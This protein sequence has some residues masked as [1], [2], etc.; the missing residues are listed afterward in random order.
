MVAT[1]A[2]SGNVQVLQNG[3]MSNGGPFT[4]NTPQITSID[5]TS[6]ASGMTVTISGTG[7]GRQSTGTVWL[8]STF[9]Q[10]TSWTD[11]Q[12]VAVVAPTA[13]TGS[14]ASNRMEHGATR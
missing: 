6:G 4:V 1:G 2:A 10:V 9:G 5:P 11:T 8:G 12:V 13:V 7:F 14:L 3:V